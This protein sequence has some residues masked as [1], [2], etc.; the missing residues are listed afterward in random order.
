MDYPMLQFVFLIG[1]TAVVI[2]NLV[3]DIVLVK[4]DPRVK[5]T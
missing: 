1:G 5:I 2:A 3:A 4:L